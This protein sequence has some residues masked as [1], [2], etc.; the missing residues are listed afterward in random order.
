MVKKLDGKKINH[1]SFI[2]NNEKTNLL[3][4]VRIKNKEIMQN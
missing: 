1:K 4:T 2:E 3:E